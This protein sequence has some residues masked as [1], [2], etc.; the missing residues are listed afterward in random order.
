MTT[1]KVAVQEIDYFLQILVKAPNR[2]L[3]G[4]LTKHVRDLEKGTEKDDATAPL[5]NLVVDQVEVA[6][7]QDPEVVVAIEITET[8]ETEIG[9]IVIAIVIVIIGIMKEAD[10]SIAGARIRI[11]RVD[12]NRKLFL[13]RK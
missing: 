5:V 3:N 12:E 10:E 1:I 7:I 11:P 6:P 9:I 13:A 2:L 4:I 8:T